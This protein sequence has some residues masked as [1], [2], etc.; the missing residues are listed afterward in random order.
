M[1]PSSLFFLI[2]VALVWLGTGTLFLG[3]RREVTFSEIF[4]KG[5]SFYD[6]LEQFYYRPNVRAFRFCCYGG[7]LC[8]YAGLAF[9]FAG[10]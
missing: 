1:Y 7:L 4:V 3:K 8:T 2:G 6:D 5:R 9:L 10:R